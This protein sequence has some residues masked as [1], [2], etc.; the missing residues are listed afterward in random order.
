MAQGFLRCFGE[1][2][3]D[4]NRLQ[5]D[6]YSRCDEGHAT[7]FPVAES[8]W[9]VSLYLLNHD[10]NLNKGAVITI[11]HL[12]RSAISHALPES[13]EYCDGMLHRVKSRLG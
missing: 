13:T 2:S 4:Q 5:L 1:I 8:S 10:I 7:P 12:S 6:V 9:A 3:C 11:T